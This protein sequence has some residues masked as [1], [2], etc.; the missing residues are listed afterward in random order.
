MDRFKDVLVNL[1]NEAD[2]ERAKRSSSERAMY[3]IALDKKLNELRLMAEGL[4][5]SFS[6]KTETL[7]KELFIAEDTATVM[8]ARIA[9]QWIDFWG[10]V[11]AFAYEDDRNK[12]AIARC[13]IVR[14]LLE[15]NRLEQSFLHDDELWRIGS[16]FVS[17]SVL[18][19]KTLMQQFT[20]VCIKF[21]GL[22]SMDMG[23]KLK[24]LDYDSRLPLI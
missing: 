18:M 16:L 19:H 2:M 23:N 1:F 12:F 10:S 17:K 3:D 24:S 14:D 5:N 22:F 11:E 13:V 6:V 4:V 15:F 9:L 8:F 20:D 7:A 21:I